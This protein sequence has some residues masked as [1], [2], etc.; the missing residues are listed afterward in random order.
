VTGIIWYQRDLRIA[1]HLGLASASQLCDA[2]LPVYIL[3]KWNQHHNW[4]GSK[5]QQFLCDCLASLSAGL[6]ELGGRLIIRS[7]SALDAIR[8]LIIE[9]RA[10]ILF[11]QKALDPHGRKVEADITTMCAAMGVKVHSFQDVCLLDPDEV[12]TAENKPYR[13]Y[14]PFSKN[15]LAREKS[16]PVPTIASLR[17]P[18]DIASED[19]PTLA[20][21]GLSFENRLQ[22]AAGENASQHRFE[23]ALQERIRQYHDFRDIPAVTGTS[24]I[25]Q[26]L[27]FGLISL[28]SIAVRLSDAMKNASPAEKTGIHTFLKELAWRDFYFAI[29]S[30]FPEVL[31][32][33]FAPQW[34]GLPWDEPD[35]KLLA[36]QSGT[37]GFPIVD[38]GMR[39]LLATGFMHNRV[40]MITSMFFTKDLH[41]DWRIGESWFMQ[42][43][44]DGEIASNNGGWQW[45]AGTGADAAPY[46]RIQN[47]WTQTARYDPDGIYIKRWIPELAKVDARSFYS[48]P[49]N[50]PLAPDYPLP[51]LNHDTERLRCLEIFKHHKARQ[52]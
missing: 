46:F 18:P 48:P 35:E 44:L 11:L 37:T 43:L 29:L 49:S 27:R 47:P 10:E 40:R 12:L 50:R 15:W 16:K 51:I 38:A 23:I 9:S 24:R 7:G 28:R 21:W 45:S 1:D 8:T 34:R 52:Q 19:L 2:V 41:Y 14:T 39:E 32:E 20:T 5:R 26:D 31:H 25:S 6:R 30:H 42:H 22:I 4:T 17:T 36:W 3:S 33:E 13:V